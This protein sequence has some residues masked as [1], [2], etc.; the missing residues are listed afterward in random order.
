MA[1]ILPD[2]VQLLSSRGATRY[3]QEAVTQLE[4]ALQ[5]ASLAEQT[6]AH[7]TL[8]AACLLHDIGHFL[9]ASRDI[10]FNPSLDDVHQY[11]AIPFLCPIFPNAVLQPICLHVDA[12]RYLCRAEAGYWEALSP[13]SKR[14]LE[15][16]GGIF[17]AEE[18][19]RFIAKSYAADAVQLR[20]WDDLAK[21][22]GKAT[23]S[24]ADY[25]HLLPDCMSEAQ[26]LL[27]P[28]Q[29]KL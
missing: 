11:R 14:S 17:N 15:R 8:A 7:D 25:V 19:E 16:Q 20:R 29:C 28:A 1:P 13:A 23:P 3:G 12:K 22:P 2:I 5:C 6:G 24:L 26:S 21:I 18:A 10:E 4:H 9:V 27:T